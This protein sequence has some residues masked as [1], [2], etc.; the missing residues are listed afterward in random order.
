[1]TR[2]ARGAKCG[3]PTIVDSSSLREKRSGIRSEPRA[4]PP[5]PNPSPFRKRRRLKCKWRS[6]N[7][8]SMSLSGFSNGL[9]QIIKG[10]DHA[11]QCGGCDGIDIGRLGIFADRQGLPGIERVMPEVGY[12]FPVVLG[13][14]GHFPG[15]WPTAQDKA[16]RLY[17]LV[18]IGGGFHF[19][20]LGE[21]P[22]GFKDGGIVEHDQRLQRRI[23]P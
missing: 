5:M 2:L 19:E 12:L 22:G 20:A 9:L 11:H 21:D 8:F 4:T 15:G 7:S 10:I 18:V 17:N 23:G 13:E 14:G 16:K 6:S 3:R 1:M